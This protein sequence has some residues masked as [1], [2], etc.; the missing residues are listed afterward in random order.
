MTYDGTAGE[1]LAHIFGQHP[2]KRECLLINRITL[3]E[4][5]A[6]ELQET[7][8]E[9]QQRNAELAREVALLKSML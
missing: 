3:L 9:L 5:Y 1:T 7:V 8:E 4:N 6:L 2:S